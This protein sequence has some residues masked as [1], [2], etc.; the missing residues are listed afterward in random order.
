VQFEPS[1]AA[2]GAIV[3]RLLATLP[4]D[5]LKID[6]SGIEPIIRQ[7]YEGKLKLPGVQ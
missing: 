1:Q 6:E 4:V 3:G 5:D 7:L 2:S